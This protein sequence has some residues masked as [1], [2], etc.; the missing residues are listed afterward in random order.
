MG[1]FKAPCLSYRMTF[2]V[3]FVGPLDL[4]A[5]YLLVIPLL[6]IPL[7]LYIQQAYICWLYL[8]FVGYIQQAKYF[9]GYA[10]PYW[11]YL[12]VLV[13]GPTV[14]DHMGYHPNKYMFTLNSYLS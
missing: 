8:Y 2:F 9:V 4:Q 5:L 14:W 7:D 11:R 1:I 12:S 10:T 13:L 3:L 6:V